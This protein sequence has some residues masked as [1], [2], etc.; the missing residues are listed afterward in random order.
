MLIHKKKMGRRG[1]YLALA[2]ATQT[3]LQLDF[4]I[5]CSQPRLLQDRDAARM[6]IDNVQIRSA[7]SPSYL[8]R[9]PA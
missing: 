3:L 6:D 2:K 1:G 4:N 7:D 5:W 8:F 9:G